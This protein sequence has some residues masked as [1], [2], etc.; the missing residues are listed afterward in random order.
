[1]EKIYLLEKMYIYMA[2]IFVLCIY[3]LMK[4][5]RKKKLGDYCVVIL[6]QFFLFQ[7]SVSDDISSYNYSEEVT[8]SY[9]WLKT[10]DTKN[11]DSERGQSILNHWI[12]SN[13]MRWNEGPFDFVCG[14]EKYRKMETF[15]NDWPIL[16]CTTITD[17][18]IDQDY[19]FGPI[20]QLTYEHFKKFMSTVIDH[21]LEHNKT[22]MKMSDAKKFMKIISGSY[23]D[24]NEKVAASLHLL[25]YLHPPS[26]RM[27]CMN[28]EKNSSMSY[29]PAAVDCQNSFLT[30]VPEVIV[31]CIVLFFSYLHSELHSTFII[32]R[33]LI[34]QSKDTF[35]D[36]IDKRQGWLVDTEE[37]V[38]PFI[39]AIGKDIDNITSSYVY[40]SEGVIVEMKSCLEAFDFLFKLHKISRVRFPLETR[41]LWYFIEREIYQITS[42]KYLSSG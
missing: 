32:F 18:L 40:V 24:E 41:H 26:T 28:I 6:I 35:N 9:S 19:E 7:I 3:C 16:T 34:L 31:F 11:I 38:P 30:L 5:E 25:S 8:S 15:M 20:L 1:M 12:K 21:H 33:I 37:P 42:D 4:L 13:V 2:S 27:Q 23:S 14:S 29:K 36:A 10:V 39:I 22:K 17:A